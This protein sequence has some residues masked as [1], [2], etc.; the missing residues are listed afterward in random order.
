MNTEYKMEVL[1]SPHPHDNS[2]R[3]YFWVILKYVN[4]KWVNTG[5]SGW[6]KT[7]EV[8]CSDA[9]KEYQKLDLK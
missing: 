7:P 5:H 9:I 4:E 2:K 1:I 8:A 6:S 3:P